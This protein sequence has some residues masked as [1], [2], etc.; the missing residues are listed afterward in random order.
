MLNMSKLPVIGMPRVEFVEEN[1]ARWTFA[2]ADRKVQE[3]EFD[4]WGGW[5]G[6]DETDGPHE[7]GGNV[8]FVGRRSFKH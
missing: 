1:L 6:F 2:T 3:R 7:V 5:F 4:Y 8:W